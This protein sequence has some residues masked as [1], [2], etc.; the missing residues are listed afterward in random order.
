[1]FFLKKEKFKRKKFFQKIFLKFFKKFFK[2][3]KNEK[4]KK[5]KTFLK[6]KKLAGDFF[7]KF[8]RNIRI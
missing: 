2:K 4:E 1:M 3:N 7:Q 5:E 8:R 6:I